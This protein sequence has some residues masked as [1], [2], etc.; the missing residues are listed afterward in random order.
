M[1]RPFVPNKQLVLV[2]LFFFSMF[3]LQAQKPLNTGEVQNRLEVKLADAYDQLSNGTADK[4][5]VKITELFMATL[6]QHFEEGKS[7][8]NALEV[9]QKIAQRKYPDF[10]DKILRIKDEIA[11]IIQKE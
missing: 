3:T 2:I 7:A 8:N 9:A 6:I 5:D 11:A 1:K 4:F 10:T